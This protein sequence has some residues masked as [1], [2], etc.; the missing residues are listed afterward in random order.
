VLDLDCG[1]GAVL[2]AVARRLG[3]GSRVTGIDRWSAL[4]QSGNARTVDPGA[5]GART[6][7]RAAVDTGDLR[8]LPY[9]DGSFDLV[10]SSLAI[11]NI[12]RRA[13]RAQALC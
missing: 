8:A 7:D 5:R 4:D 3:A 13:E 1:R 12:R 2:M 11:H 6:G 9:A 10:V